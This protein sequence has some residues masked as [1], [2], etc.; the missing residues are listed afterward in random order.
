VALPADDLAIRGGAVDLA[1]LRLARTGM[2]P[3]HGQKTNSAGSTGSD[4]LLAVCTAGDSQLEWLRAG[5][6]LSAL[7]LRATADGLSIVPLTQVIE[8]EQ[9]RHAMHHE[10]F[11]GMARPQILVR[12][13]WQEISRAGR[14]PTPRRARGPP[15][16]TAFPRDLI[17]YC[18]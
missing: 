1:G 9:T 8:M 6:S 15:V 10:I 5:E 12:V 16:V 11:D 3:R 18:G 2:P 13:G 7:W 14:T 4:G 17:H